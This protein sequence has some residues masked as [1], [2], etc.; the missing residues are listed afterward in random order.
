M[1]GEKYG[2]HFA[3]LPGR[4]MHAANGNVGMSCI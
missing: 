1:G 3:V 2:E 4:F